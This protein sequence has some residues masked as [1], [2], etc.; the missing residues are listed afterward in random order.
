MQA[1]GEDGTGAEYLNTELTNPKSG[2]YEYAS[3]LK[4][5]EHEFYR[6]E[7]F[8]IPLSLI[9]FDMLHKEP[10]TTDALTAAGLRISMMGRRVDRAGHFETH[11]ALLLPATTQAAGG[12]IA[13]RVFGA[14]S[15][16][17]LAPGFDKSTIRFSFGVAGL[18]EDG[19]SIENLIIAAKLANNSA[20]SLVY[21]VVVSGG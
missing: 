14:L 11:F 5:L 18:P 9:I 13:T 8:R 15:A 21:P 17:P 19:S 20:R 16:A 4:F 10:L 2:F 7:A 3:I 1:L 12:L 6:F